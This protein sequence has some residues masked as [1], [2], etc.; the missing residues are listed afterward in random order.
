MLL[1]EWKTEDAK[2]VWY[3]EGREE[4]RISEREEIVRQALV[5][6]LPIETIH[7]ITG[8]DIDTIK[9]IQARF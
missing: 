5:K 8:L 1:T 7:D 4:G 2:E 3:A 9:N 6:K